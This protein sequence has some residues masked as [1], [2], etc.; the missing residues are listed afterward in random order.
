LAVTSHIEK[1]PTEAVF[2][3]VTITG[4]GSDGPWLNRDVGIYGNKAERLYV[5]VDDAI[6]YHDDPNATLIEPWTQW[7]IPLQ[8][9]A[10][11]GANLTDANN[12]FIGIG[13]PSDTLRSGSEGQ[14]F[15][16]DIRLYL[17]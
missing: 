1:V 11:Q 2:S 17:P 16:D 9:F 10:D 3:N 5:A 13:T 12:L 7:R 4:T 15:I 8:D 6:V 14:I